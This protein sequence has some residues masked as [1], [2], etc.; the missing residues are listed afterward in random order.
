MLLRPGGIGADAIAR[1]LG[2][3]A[4]AGRCVARPAR[5]ERSP[6]HYAPRTPAQLVAHD[7]LRAELAQLEDRDERVAV[8][9]RSAEPPEAFDGV[10]LAAPQRR[11]ATTRARCTRT[12]ARST[13]PT[14]T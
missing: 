13:T 12:C 5:R 3:S 1:V 14:P 7:V 6:S 9:A 8:L 11:D 10:W 4:R 2:T